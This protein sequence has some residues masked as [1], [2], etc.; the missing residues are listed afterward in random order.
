MTQAPSI[1][2]FSTDDHPIVTIGVAAILE[3]DPCKEL[4][5]IAHSADEM[6]RLLARTRPDVL[7]LDLNIP[8]S[9]YYQNI[10]QLKK[11]FSRIR[12]LIYSA[13]QAP[14]LPRSLLNEGIEGYVMKSVLPEELLTAI[15]AVYRGEIYLSAGII[16]PHTKPD[17]GCGAGTL[18][19]DDFRKSLSLSHREQEVL[20][21]ISRGFTSQLIGET[22]F[23][24]KHT[25]ETHRKNILRKLDF[26]SSTELVKFA[27]QQ[28]L[29]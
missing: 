7:L 1:R 8:G 19:K 29:V 28:G 16:G 13:Y 4:V 11:Q 15:E 5:G 2:V 21:L 25:V 26:N 20:Q 27:V 9:D 6:F 22:L 10:R 24:S 17:N 18:L 14:G 3:K 23:I 12:I